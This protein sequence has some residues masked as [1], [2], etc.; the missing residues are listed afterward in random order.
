LVPAANQYRASF[1]RQFFN[2]GLATEKV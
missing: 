2:D 1:P